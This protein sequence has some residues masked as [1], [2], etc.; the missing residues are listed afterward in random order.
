MRLLSGPFDTKSV[1]FLRVFFFFFLFPTIESFISISLFGPRERYVNQAQFLPEIFN[2]KDNNNNIYV[3]SSS[4][5][6][7]IESVQVCLFSSSFFPFFFSPPISQPPLGSVER[8]LPSQN[9]PRAWGKRAIHHP[10]KASLK[11]RLVSTSR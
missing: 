8:T 9:S 6:R 4:Y 3:R 10:F 1:R 7:C 11:G 2:N 5:Q